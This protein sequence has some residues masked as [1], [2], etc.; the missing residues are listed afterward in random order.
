MWCRARRRIPLANKLRRNLPAKLAYHMIRWRNVMWGMFFFQLSRR[1]PAKVKQ[2]ILGGVQMAL[3][4]DY[5][6]ATHFTPRYNPWDQRLCLVP[7]GDLFKAIREQRA[8]V[9]TNEIDTFTQ[10]GIRL[11]DGSELAADIIVTA[12]GLVLQVL[13]GLEVSVDGRAIDFAKTLNYKGMMYSD[14][15]NMASAFGYTNASWTLKCDL[16][17]EYVCRLINYMDRHDYRQCM[18][19]NDDPTIDRTAIARFLVGLCAALG[20]EDAEARL[21]AAV[22]ALPELRARH[23]LLAVRQDRRRRDA[24]FLIASPRSSKPCGWQAAA[25]DQSRVRAQW[26]RRPARTGRDNHRP[27][28]ERAGEYS[29]PGS[30]HRDRRRRTGRTILRRS[31]PGISGV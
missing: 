5:D 25:Q 17:C 19:H 24:I 6:V 26:R 11:K 13:G 3:G 21:E 12:T 23:R 28:R 14:V 4:P 9:V 27:R 15:P 10:N 29:R 30:L 31:G 7:D 22:A 8:S 18:P 2:L 16:T 1:K 20:R